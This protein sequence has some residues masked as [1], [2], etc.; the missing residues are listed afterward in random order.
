MKMPSNPPADN[1]TGWRMALD[2][3]AAYVETD[4]SKE[5][6]APTHP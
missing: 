4:R 6:L 5:D 2:K 3:L 1:D